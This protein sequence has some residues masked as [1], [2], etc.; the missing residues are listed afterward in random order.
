MHGKLAVILGV[1]PARG[2]EAWRARI[3]VVLQSW[4]DH[5]FWRVR[6]L[7]AYLA[8]FY[9]PFATAA[10]P[11]PWDVDELM[12]ATEVRWTSGRRRHVHAERQGDPTNFVRDLLTKNAD[13]T[14]LEV[15]RS[16]LQD[17]YMT[18]VRRVESYPSRGGGKP[19][20]SAAKKPEMHV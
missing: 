8:R 3:G 14:D 20:A 1:D 10:V 2:N 6:E 7:L 18:L 19:G 5:R 11:R 4:R 15:R 12:T 16:S 9:A 17:T 13:V